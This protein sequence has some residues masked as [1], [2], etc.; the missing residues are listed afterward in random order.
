MRLSLL[1]LVA[2]LGSGCVAFTPVAGTPVTTP[3]GSQTVEVVEFTGNGDTMLAAVEALRQ[4]RGTP[5][6]HR[7]VEVTA[8]DGTLWQGEELQFGDGTTALMQPV[9]SGGAAALRIDAPGD[10]A[11]DA[12]LT[13]TSLRSA[14]VFARPAPEIRFVR[15]RLSGDDLWSFDVTLAYPDTGWNDYADGWHVATPAGEILGT[16]VL[17]HPHVNEQPFTR[18]LGNVVIPADVD[19]V[20]VRAHTLVAGYGPVTVTVPLT[21]SV[22]SAQYDVARP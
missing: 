20:V 2:L 1:I 9:N 16:R 18:S 7:F 4:E 11:W 15:A 8:A 12:A 14:D 5:V 21:Q 17:L 3:P 19:T 13:D 10:I 22:Q 6:A